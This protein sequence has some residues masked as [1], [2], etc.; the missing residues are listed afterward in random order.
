[1]AAANSNVQLS[2]LDFDGI[3]ENL[4]T[5][6]KSQSTFQDYNFEGSALSTLLNVL[7]YNTHY[8]AYYLNMVANEMFMD[9]AVL[10]SS[11][12]SHAKLLNYTPKSATSPKATVNVIAYDVPT[13]SLTIP[14]FTKFASEA[15]EGINYPFVTTDSITVNTV[16]NTASFFDLEITQGEPISLTFTYTSATNLKSLFVLPDVNIDTSTLLIQV[17]DSIS[18]TNIETYTL[19]QNITSVTPDSKVYF[20]QE[21]LT[22]N[23]E[24]YFGDNVLGKKL[25]DGNVVLVSYLVTNGR[26]SSG[27]NNF[28]LL[29]TI[30]SGN[31]SVTSVVSASEGKEKESIESI[32]YQAPKSYASQGRAVSYEDYITAI[33]QNN[34]GFS[35]GSVSVWGGEDNIPPAYGQVFISV[36]P[37][38][39]LT[40]SD[41][42]KK[43][44]V[45]DVIKPISVVTVKPTIVDPDYVFI[46][47][48]ADV[49]Y[50]QKQTTLTS[51]QIQQSV[52]QAIANFATQTLG[53]FNSTFSYS[54]LTLAIQNASSSILTNN[55]KINVIK[56][57]FPVL[58]VPR[59]YILNYGVPLQR[60][61]Y[62]SGIVSYPTVRYFTSGSDIRLINDV[63]VE[64]VPFATSGIDSI[65]ILNPGFNY[66]RAP[67]VVITGDGSG[68]KARAIVK[69]GYIS[70]IVVEDP[71][72][73]YTQAIV[74]I[75]NADDDFSGTNG[76]AFANLQGRFG[77]L[78]SYYFD[79]NIK[80]ILNSNLGIIDYVD[81]IITLPNFAPNDVND[82]L[83][84]LSLIANPKSNIVA[85]S[86]NKIISIDLFDPN[87][88]IVNVLAK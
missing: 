43:R 80:I 81:G 60:S 59:Q 44:L 8:N 78:R 49:V 12:V 35:I 19:V 57:F 71:G 48:I 17:Q 9:T 15:V 84:Q 37:T 11:V 77:T 5:Y 2:N 55:C 73:N 39:G 33:Q 1:M 25:N 47:V 46:K 87:S 66:T 82:P 23:Y 76:S 27:A 21:G 62:E 16:A 53:T 28:V 3:K 20:L 26:L 4:K 74:S 68:A 86:R 30:G 42:Q 54:D 79:N 85:S 61:V 38:N 24:I 69:N 67:D 40:L 72:N 65:S 10:R 88:I 7:A 6:L 14:K 22:G 31:N 32:K 64:E 75:V 51:N 18:N 29:D 13:A 58:D 34:L 56:K 63:Y 41:S 36:K 52:R 70:E 45:D 83:G 50:D